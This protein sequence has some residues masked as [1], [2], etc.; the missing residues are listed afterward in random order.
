[1]ETLNIFIFQNELPQANHLKGLLESHGYEV[2]WTQLYPNDHL[3]PM[4]QE[5]SSYAFLD[6]QK[7]KIE[8]EKPVEKRY[9]ESDQKE[10]KSDEIPL[11][12]NLSTKKNKPIRSRVTGNDFD[13]DEIFRSKKVNYQSTNLSDFGRK[14]PSSSHSFIFEDSF[15]IRSNSALVKL[16][17]EDIVYFEADAN[18]TQIFTEEK[19]FIIR[20][21]LKELEEKLNDKRFARVHKSFMINLEKIENI[22]ADFIQI[23]DKEIPIGRQ[24]YR[25]LTGKIKI[26]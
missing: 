20:A 17:L 5:L 22:Q 15:F 3:D 1:M 16:R 14:K 8:H 12:F 24:Q 7:S 18:Y 26:L 6:I 2:K 10:S 13:L 19:K 4:C 21:S 11:F 9:E 23:A 25:W